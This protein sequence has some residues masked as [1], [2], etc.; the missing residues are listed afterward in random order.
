MLS[1]NTNYIMSSNEMVLENFF[2]SLISYLL[3]RHLERKK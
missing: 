1:V 3:D 2:K